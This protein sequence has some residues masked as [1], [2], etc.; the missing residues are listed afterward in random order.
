MYKYI[1]DIK[2]ERERMTK[3]IKKLGITVYPS[4][5]NFLLIKSNIHDLPQKLQERGIIVSN[6]S[7]YS[8]TSEFIRVTI[9][10]REENDIFIETV[11]SIL[12]SQ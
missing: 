1:D 9:S 2:R 12:E 3:S 7:H 4:Y 8:L 10:T 6:L 11:Q 5:S